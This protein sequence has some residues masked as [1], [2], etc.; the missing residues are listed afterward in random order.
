MTIIWNEIDRKR[1]EGCVEPWVAASAKSA[2]ATQHIFTL[3][4]DKS[5]VKQ[6]NLSQLGSPMPRTSLRVGIR[7]YRIN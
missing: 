2:R 1:P 3:C 5:N 7:E 4:P 6:T